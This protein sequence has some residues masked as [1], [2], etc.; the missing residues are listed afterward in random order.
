MSMREG[1]ET[2]DLAGE[3]DWRDSAACIGLVQEVEFFPERGDSVRAAKAV[4]AACRV[5][6]RCLEFA[7]RERV[8]CGIWGGLT[9]RERRQLRRRQI[10]PD[11][12][13]AP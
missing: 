2:V 7:L 6:E 10:C 4:C 9:G 13:R 3:R 12:I 5:R 1:L 8:S 11:E